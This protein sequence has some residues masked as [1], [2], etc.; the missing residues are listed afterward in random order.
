[1]ISRYCFEQFKTVGH[2]CGKVRERRLAEG[3]AGF[4]GKVM[5]RMRKSRI[6]S[7]WNIRVSRYFLLLVAVCWFANP[8]AASDTHYGLG[9]MHLLRPGTAAIAD[10]D[11]DQIPDIAT[12]IRTGQTGEGYSYRVDLDLSTN[13]QA[14]PFN[15]V[16]QDLIDLKIEAVDIDDDHDLDLL[17]TGRFSMQPIGI[18]LNDGRGGFTRG[19]LAK[20]VVPVWEKRPAVQSS[21]SNANVV[22]HFGRRS[23]LALRGEKLGSNTP[24]SPFEK[25][26]FLSFNLLQVASGA[27]RFRAP[28]VPSI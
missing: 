22:V 13:S 21:S 10:L 27:A 4:C 6:S 17:V 26:R 14:K 23:Q 5:N 7:I 8:A 2:F 11:G 25:A 3:I 12:G 24:S 19:D 28:P 18:W 9:P 20:Y 1:M 16:S 15:V